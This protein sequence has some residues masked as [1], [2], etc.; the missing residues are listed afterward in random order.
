MS[1]LQLLWFV[2]I[3]ILFSGFFFLEGFDFGVGMSVQTLAH[4][5]EEKE[6]IIQTIGP[7]WDGNEVWLLT[8]GGAMFASF[9]YW[10]ASLFSGFYLIL[11]IILV[12]LIIRG[13]SFEFRHRMPDGKRRR[14]W[15]WTLSIGSFI[16]PFFFGVLFIDLVQGMPLDADGNMMATF[17][18]Y[19][20]VFSVV[21][22]VALALLCYLHGLNYITLK[23]EGPV[24]E[25]ARNYAK[26]FYWILYIGLVVF[27]AL[28]YF[29]T[30]FFDNHFLLTLLLV[31]G[32]VAVTVVA[33]VSVFKEKEMLAFIA[34]GLTL[35]LLVALLFSGLFPRVMIGSE[36]YYDILIKDAS[37][38]PYT[39]KTMTWLSLTILPFVLA[40]TAWSY[41]IFRKRIK[42]P[43]IAAVGYEG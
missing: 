17:T 36:G 15:N 11:F 22:G 1:T 42:H 40:Y 24:R 16:V 30:D 38:S 6:Q 19:I 18:D 28:L 31:V 4:D 41:Y 7:V 9:P 43:A 27:A 33:N 14:M 34:S 21:G 32:I 39:L 35:I 12:G 2:L 29:K 3:G 25:R 23:T 26:L 5:E 20:N 37:S 8:A 10:Y 13:V